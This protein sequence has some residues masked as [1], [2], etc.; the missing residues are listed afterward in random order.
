MVVSVLPARAKDNR[1]SV[2]PDYGDGVRIVLVSRFGDKLP[3]VHPFGFEACERVAVV[4][5]ADDVH[6]RDPVD[7]VVAEFWVFYKVLHRYPYLF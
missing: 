2:P 7:R 4:F 3:D 5:V 1:V 6:R